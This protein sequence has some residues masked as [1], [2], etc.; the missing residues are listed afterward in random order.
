MDEPFGLKRFG[1][2]RIGE[3][4]GLPDGFRAKMERNMRFNDDAHCWNS[5]LTNAEVYVLIDGIL[6]QSGEMTPIRRMF[7][8]IASKRPT[9]DAARS[10]PH[11]PGI[12]RTKLQERPWK[13]QARSESSSTLLLRAGK[14]CNSHPKSP[15]RLRIL[16]VNTTFISRP[17]A[18]SH[19]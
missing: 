9:T 10:P 19:R 18:V 7:C 11:I 14:R 2:I 16:A 17:E 5:P 13:K 15:K 1:E 3:A 8:T 12:R 4:L 6:F